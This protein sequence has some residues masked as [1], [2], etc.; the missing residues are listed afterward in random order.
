MIHVSSVRW[1][2]PTNAAPFADT[3]TFLRLRPNVPKWL[4]EWL[5]AHLVVIDLDA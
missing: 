2:P 1:M 4:P 3:G 5:D